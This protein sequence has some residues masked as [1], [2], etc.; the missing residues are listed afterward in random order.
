M[1][2][3]FGA[4]FKNS[5]LDFERILAGTAAQKPSAG[6]RAEVPAPDAEPATEAQMD[7]LRKLAHQVTGDGDAHIAALQ[8]SRV[9]TKA[10]ATLELNALKSQ[11]TPEMKAAGSRRRGPNRSGTALVTSASGAATTNAPV[12]RY[13]VDLPEWGGT[14]LVEITKPTSGRWAG[15]SFVKT[16][17]RLGAPFDEPVKGAQAVAVFNAIESDPIGCSSMFGRVTGR[18]GICNR[19]LSEPNSQAV[20]IGPE[21]RTQFSGLSNGRYDAP[22][23]SVPGA[24][25]PERTQ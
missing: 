24:Q 8:S 1:D 12:G 17:A 5:G 20:G 10:A 23:R 9:L 19:R 14:M 16:P 2:V 15:Y 22:S 21:C 6:Q 3:D 11:L 4:L 25:A 18:C 7:Y 13:C